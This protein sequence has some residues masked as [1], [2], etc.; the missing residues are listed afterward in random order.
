MSDYLYRIGAFLRFYKRQQM[1][2]EYTPHLY[3]ILF[4]MY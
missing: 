4:K 2:M 3:S 1:Y